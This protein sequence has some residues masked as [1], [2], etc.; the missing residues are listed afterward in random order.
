M[1]SIHSLLFYLSNPLDVAL[2]VCLDDL[3]SSDCY[4]LGNIAINAPAVSDYFSDSLLS[5]ISSLTY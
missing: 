4:F 5:T 1:A 3:F 2:I